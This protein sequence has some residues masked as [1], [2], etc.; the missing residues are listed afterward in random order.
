[1]DKNPDNIPY[2][3]HHID[4]NDIDSVIKVLNSDFITQGP[5]VPLFEKIISRYCG[6]KY[7]VAVNSSTS[8][9]HLACISLGLKENDWL[10]TSPISF[11][12]SANCGLYCGAKIDF[13][14][15]DPNNF[16]LCPSALEKKLILAEKNGKLPKVL[17]PVHLCGQSCD[18]KS[19]YKLSKKYGFKIIEDASHAIG[20]KYLNQ[21]IGCCSYSDI[22]VFSFH[23]VKIITTGEG[24]MALT[25]K[26]KYADKMRLLRTHGITREPTLMKGKSPGKWFYQ[27]IDLGYNYRMTDIQAALGISQF[28][29]LDSIVSKR[30][31]LAKR[32][33]KLLSKLPL[34]LPYRNKNILSS[35]HLYVIRL[36]DTQKHK[37][38]FDSLR[39]SG[40]GV[41]LHY[42]PIYRHPYYNN[43]KNLIKQFPE[44]ESYYASAITIPLFANMSRVEQDYIVKEIEKY[45]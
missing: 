41:N 36:I 14:D 45:L 35:F 30:N 8:A 32:Y 5:Q 1:M 3:Q 9:L 11:V 6:S 2:G 31:T 26:K 25:N 38:V 21:P 4:K 12:A 15:I 10:W 19:I 24:G 16:N 17:I 28:K 39:K 20:G 22:T 7:A 37:F 13:V 43:A 34:K 40:I 27:Q 42:I 23:P 29:R 18:M 33:D 44:S